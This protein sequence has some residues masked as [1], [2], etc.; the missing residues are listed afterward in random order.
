MVYIDRFLK[1]LNMHL[2][3]SNWRP[4]TYSALMMASKQWEDLN[5]LNSDF[6]YAQKMYSLNAINY[7]EK[8]FLELIDW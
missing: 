2:S 8:L 5:P 7:L 3:G 1:K 4:I 6:M